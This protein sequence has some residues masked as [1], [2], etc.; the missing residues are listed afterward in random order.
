[1]PQRPH[2]SAFFILIHPVTSLFDLCPPFSNTDLSNIVSSPNYLIP[3]YPIAVP[4]SRIR[5]SQNLAIFY[6]KLM[7]PEGGFELDSN[8]SR[9]ALNKAK[10]RP[11][12][13]LCTFKVEGC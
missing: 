9:T 3:D 6:S 5:F 10:I 4:Y 7:G 13:T 2:K 12:E 11:P 1:M 8:R